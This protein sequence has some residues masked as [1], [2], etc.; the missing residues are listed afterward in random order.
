MLT[1]TIGSP[2]NVRREII[3]LSVTK[4]NYNE[5]VRSIMNLPEKKVSSYVCFANVHM[6]VECYKDARL[7]QIVKQADL[8]APDGKPIAVLAALLGEGGQEKISGPDVFRDVLTACE[9]L[10]KSV[11]FYGSS[12]TV[13]VKLLSRVARDFPLL[14]VCGSHSPPYRELTVEENQKVISSINLA[15]PDFVFVAL[16]CPKQET[17]M[18]NHQGVLSTCMLGVGQAFEIYAGELR[19]SPKW[20]QNVGLEW[21]FRLCSEPWRLWKRYLYTNSIFLLLVLKLGI[22]KLI[23]EKQHNL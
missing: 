17:W 19:R 13:L 7:K 10:S 1:R 4:L 12:D 15:M 20:M 18:A 6:L 5:F 8:V 11:F 23:N 3:S 2:E 14:N 16:G 22:G 9:R 21:L